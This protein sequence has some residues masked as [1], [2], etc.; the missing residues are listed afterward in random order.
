[1]LGTELIFL[2]QPPEYRSHRLGHH[3]PPWKG[4]SETLRGMTDVSG[5]SANDA[6]VTVTGNKWMEAAHGPVS[7]RDDSVSLASEL[8]KQ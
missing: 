8:L 5:G 6:D 2:L 1:M 4:G 7:T 3:G